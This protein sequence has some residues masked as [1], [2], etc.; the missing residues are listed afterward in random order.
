[1]N[2]LP[3]FP[4]EL[5]LDTLEYVDDPEALWITVRL[6]S[7]RF[8]DLVERVFIQRQLPT[9]CMSLSLPRH[10]PSTG[11]L[12][13]KPPVP[14]S[15]LVFAFTG[16]DD[17]QDTVILKTPVLSNGVSVESLTNTG[18]LTQ[19]RLEEASGW[20]W[21]GRNRG[22]GA[23]VRFPKTMHWDTEEKKWSC[24][25]P[26]KKLVGAFFKSKEHRR[27]SQVQSSRRRGRV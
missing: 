24:V 18:I 14:G 6:V 8:K 25:L 22:K 13:Y 1:M 12:R 10:D 26:W 16:F 9:I 23:N 5:W 27:L 2:A 4:I 19:Q 20:T 15:E 17:Q 21:F 3:H 7:R 11:A